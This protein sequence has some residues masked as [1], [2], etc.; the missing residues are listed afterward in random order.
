MNIRHTY[1][2]E[3]ILRLHTMSQFPFASCMYSMYPLTC[4]P[5]IEVIVEEVRLI[6]I[7]LEDEVFAFLLM[8]E[9]IYLPV[10][11]YSNEQEEKEN[12]YFGESSGTIYSLSYIHESGIPMTQEFQS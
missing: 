3:Y 5:D 6:Q 4:F 9:Q 1:A 2:G 12:T 10:K 7:K 11:I 8:P